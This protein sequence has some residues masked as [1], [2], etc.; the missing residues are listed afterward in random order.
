MKSLLLTLTILIISSA[1]FASDIDVS[2]KWAGVYSGMGTMTYEFLVEGNKLYGTTIGE[3]DSRID[4]VKGKVKTS[5]KKG[6]EISFEVPVSIGG[7]KMSI[8]YTGEVIDENTIELTF[9]TRARGSRNVG[10]DGF[11]DG[12]G[13]GGG[14]GGGGFSSGFGGGGSSETKFVI[15]RVDHF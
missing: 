6:T 13:G 4:I 15:K 5:K 12:F 9:K 14:G 10:F 2:G 7:T 1:A 8:V 3:G 11:N